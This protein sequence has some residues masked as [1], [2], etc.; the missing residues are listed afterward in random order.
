MTSYFADT[1]FFAALLN[2]KDSAHSWARAE[3]TQILIHR[4]RV[5]TTSFVLVEL[6]SALA[7]VRTRSIFIELLESL[8]SWKVIVEPATERLL[9]KG[10]LLFGSRLDKE[11]S[12]V[13]CMS[14]VV[15]KEKRIKKALTG[16]RHFD[17][18]GF[19]SLYQT[20]T[21]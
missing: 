12:L 11:W 10:L 21:S 17:Q 19:Q 5:V 9:K 4:H 20:A 6:G 14:F 15:M 13:D 3:L 2:P 18:A 7:S 8:P 16:D 1:F